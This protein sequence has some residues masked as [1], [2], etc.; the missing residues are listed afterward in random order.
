[1]IMEDKEDDEVNISKDLFDKV[2][3]KLKERNKRA[4]DFLIKA[5]DEF[6]DSVFKLCQR[7]IREESFPARFAETI[8]YNLWK[9]K[10]SRE[11]LNNHRYIHL[12]D[13]L[14]RLAETLTAEM[15]KEDIFRKCTKYQIGGVPGHRLEEHLVALKCII[16]R[17]IEKGSGVIMQL[18][19][20]KKFFDKERL[21]TL[22][23]SL[24]SV[25]VNKK[26]YRCWYKLNKKTVFRVATPAGT[27]ESSDA[28]DLVPQGS[29]GAARASALDIGLGLEEQFSG[30]TEE[31]AYG[32]VRCNPQAFQDDIA[33]LADGIDKTNYGN[34]KI[35]QM[36]QNKGLDC[37][38]TKTTFLVIGTT[39]YQKDIEEQLKV[40]AVVF[41]SLQCKPKQ[42]D[43]YLGDVI[44]AKGLEASAQATINHR[45]GNV[46]GEMY[47]MKAIMEDFWLQAVG[48]MAGAI[49]VW[50]LGICNKLLANGGS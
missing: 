49:D 22:M 32:R 3:E 16:G 45:Q 1:M 29:G 25:N 35:A 4:Y 48:G 38:P 5:G 11:D 26:A 28:T 7:M 14:P 43:L 10:G 15:M 37:H 44:A 24:R 2:V 27:T 13:W 50:E 36:L 21:G 23:T 47:E 17:Y 19:D 8:L 9:R 30:S 34:V 33:R 6:H 41:G 42:Q 12:K 18:V 31:V 39:K 20:I 46:R 40:N